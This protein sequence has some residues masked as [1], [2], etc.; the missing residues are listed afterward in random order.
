MKYL[1][2]ITLLMSPLSH[3]DKLYLGAKSYHFDRSKDYNET[4]K[5]VMYEREGYV[6]A[7]FN[8]S[9]DEDT[10]LLGKRLYYPLTDNLTTS[11]MVGATY[12]YRSLR[13]PGDLSRSRKVLPAVTLS[14]EY[15]FGGLL[16][17]LFLGSAVAISPGVEW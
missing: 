8:N 1:I 2:L 11:V 7:Y 5:L 17:T 6:A 9:Y 15:R 12:G 16:N 4:H 14:I 10:F 3:A 13:K